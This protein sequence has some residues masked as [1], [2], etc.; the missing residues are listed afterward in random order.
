MT[1]NVADITDPFKQ[2][3]YQVLVTN[4]IGPN[5]DIAYQLSV[6]V[7]PG[8]GWTFGQ[9]QF[10]LAH[11][12]Q[13]YLDIFHE[14]L[15]NAVDSDTGIPII[16]DANGALDQI[17]VDQLYTAATSL[18]IT[19]LLDI[20]YGY[21][22]VNAALAVSV[23]EIDSTV[24]MRLQDLIVGTGDPVKL[25]ADEIIQLASTADQAWFSDPAN[26][27]GKLWMCDMLNQGATGLKEFVMG[28]TSMGYTKDGT[29]GVDDILNFYLHQ[30]ST[31]TVKING[32]RNSFANIYP[33]DA[34]RR[35]TTVVNVA[36]G[37]SINDT[38]TGLEEAKG[39]LRAYTY[40]YVPHETLLANDLGTVDAFKAVI[41]G[42]SIELLLEQP[43]H[44]DHVSS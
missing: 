26:A 11:T 28:Q 32:V 16:H 38:P 37:Y 44:V 22:L 30:R 17:L 4:E 5:L 9:F 13:K 34:L 18:D 21:S 20:P 10:D 24:D 42:V 23:A 35:F 1:I 29:I 33:A 3:L 6:P 12:D 19:Q 43:C 41:K 15:L 7:G 27:I 39:I 2:M 36:G 40:Y 8:S 25:G 14:I 31:I